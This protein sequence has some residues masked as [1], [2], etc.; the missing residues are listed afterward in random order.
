[1]GA[2]RRGLAGLGER[3]WQRRPGKS[4]SASEPPASALSGGSSG[5]QLTRTREIFG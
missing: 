1:M 3:R 2:V 5:S 4:A